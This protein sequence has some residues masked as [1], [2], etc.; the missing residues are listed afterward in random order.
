MDFK[1]FIKDEMCR[2]DE[3]GYQNLCRVQALIYGP[4]SPFDKCST[5]C[6]KTVAAGNCAKCVDIH[7]LLFRC[8][9]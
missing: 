1:D 6:E 3:E 4:I 8:V 9:K 5:P 7:D 2:C